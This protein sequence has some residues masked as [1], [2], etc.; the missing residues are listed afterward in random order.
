MVKITEVPHPKYRREGND[1][2]YVHTISLVDSLCAA[3]FE[4]ETLDHRLITIPLDEIVAPGSRRLVKGEGMPICKED[5]E[6]M[7]REQKGRPKE[8]GDL[9]IE[10]DIKFPEVVAEEKR[11]ALK[12][13]LL[14]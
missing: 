8:K 7:L 10:F 9:W 2:V 5:P 3:P 13:I 14:S 1:L 4:V 6:S 11:A 12:E